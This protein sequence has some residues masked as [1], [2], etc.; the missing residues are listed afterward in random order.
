MVR[1][2]TKTKKNEGGMFD[3]ESERTLTLCVGRESVF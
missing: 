1:G 2:R 3:R